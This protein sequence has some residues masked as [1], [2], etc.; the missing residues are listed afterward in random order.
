[1]AR[2]RAQRCV[3]R[4]HHARR[5][6]PRLAPDHWCAALA[7]DAA[8]DRRDAQPI[9]RDTRGGAGREHAT[10]PISSC[11]H[12]QPRL[13]PPHRGTHSPHAR[14]ARLVAAHSFVSHSTVRVRGVFC[15]PG[16]ERARM[17]ARVLSRPAAAPGA[18]IKVS[19]RD[20]ARARDRE[21]TH[22]RVLGFSHV[23][24]LIHI[25]HFRIRYGNG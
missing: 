3:P 23:L 5:N 1:M 22:A 20:G 18:S 9:V 21:K 16:T 7:A 25:Y 19:G 4:P 11:H 10:K 17:L 2:Q 24:T 14:L 12:R 6:A 8:A 13:M 15:R